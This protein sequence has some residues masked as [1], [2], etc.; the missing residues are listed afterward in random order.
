MIFTDTVGRFKNLT[1]SAGSDREPG[2]NDGSAG[3]TANGYRGTVTTAQR[4]G[5]RKSEAEARFGRTADLKRDI[6]RTEQT[7]GETD[8]R[9]GKLK[10]VI[11]KKREERHERMERLKS[12]RS[13]QSHGGYPGRERAPEERQ[14]GETAADIRAF[15]GSLDAEDQDERNA[16]EASIREA[17][18]NLCDRRTERGNVEA[19]EGQ[20]IAAAKQA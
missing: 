13:A 12:R 6:E 19:A 8:S 16:A 10:A 9:I 20:S 1:G 15:L 2:R 7:I 4:S 18:D 11:Q 14:L 5:G 17:Q 3:K